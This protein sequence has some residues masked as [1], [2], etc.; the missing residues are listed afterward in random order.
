MT[1]DLGLLTAI[2]AIVA[3]SPAP[4][5]DRLLAAIDAA[6]DRARAEQPQE[7]KEAD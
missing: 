1:L 7:D 5:R 3:C 6:T 4:G 2:R